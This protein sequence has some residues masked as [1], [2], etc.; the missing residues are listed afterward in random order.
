MSNAI[1]A[2]ERLRPE[3]LERV[4]RAIDELGYRPSRAA[5]TLR[6]RSSKL[7]GYG[8]QPAPLGTMAPLMDRFLHALSEAADEAGYRILLFAAPTGI[9][10][11]KSY[12]ELLDQHDVD[13]F[14]LSCTDERGGPRQAW[15]DKQG[16]PFVAFG[17]MWSKRQICDWVDVDGACGTDAAVEHLVA[18][19]HR[20]IAFLGYGRGP[21]ISEDRAAG[22]LR[23]M[24]RHQLPTRGRRAE[25]V[26]DVEAARMAVKPLLD[27]GAT[28]VVAASDTLALGCYYA[29]REQ[30]AVPGRDVAVVGFDDSPTAAILS[31][32]LTSVAQPLEA[33]G[34]E[35]VRL[36]LARIADSDAPPE[37]VLLEPSLDVRD[38]GPTPDA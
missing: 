24:Q 33:V 36:L 21:G 5:Q 4:Q 11:L 8:T 25:S 38:S 18:A 2:P 1:N 16:V 10:G 23:A 6:T 28:A 34:R 32:G 31:P 22:W 35:C 29:L 37:R 26:D 27:A 19:D 9:N 3:T 20:K 15:L 12:Q 13:G 7:I 30:R 17:R 14:V